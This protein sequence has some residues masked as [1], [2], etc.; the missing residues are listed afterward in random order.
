MSG[1]HLKHAGRPSAAVAQALA[2]VL[3]PPPSAAQAVEPSLL[4]QP[5]GAVARW[6]RRP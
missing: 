2:V 6:I 4:V 5:H 3:A 1:D